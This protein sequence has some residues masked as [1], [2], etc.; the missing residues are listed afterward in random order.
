MIMIRAPWSRPSPVGR[1][2]FSVALC[3]EEPGVCRLDA[4]TNSNLCVLEI[5]ENRNTA[6]CDSRGSS[7][8][9]EFLGRAVNAIRHFSAIRFRPRGSLSANNLGHERPDMG[10]GRAVA[11]NPVA[12]N[13]H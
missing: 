7:A 1:R 12:S 11:A 10:E 13:T 8:W 9:R 5:G 6:S 4:P 3:A 2:F